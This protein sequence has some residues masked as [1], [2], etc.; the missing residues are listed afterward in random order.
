MYYNM[1]KLV[2]RYHRATRI[3][4]A[5]TLTAYLFP[6]LILAHPSSSQIRDDTDSVH[7]GYQFVRNPTCKGSRYGNKNPLKHIQASE[8]AKLI[9]DK[10]NNN[11]TPL[12]AHS[13]YGK[14]VHMRMLPH[15]MNHHR[16]SYVPLPIEILP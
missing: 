8:G 11:Q 12:S 4:P 1:C 6:C 13:Q 16:T 5:Y 10:Y 2:Y 3:N 15:C 14:S 9:L 7:S